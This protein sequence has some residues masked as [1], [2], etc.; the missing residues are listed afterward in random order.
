VRAN[1]LLTLDTS[2]LTEVT[3]GDGEASIEQGVDSL[4]A[5]NEAVSTDVDHNYRVVSVNQSEAEVADRYI[6]NST[7]VYLDNH[8]LIAD[9]QHQSGNHVVEEVYWLRKIG[10]TWK[11]TNGATVS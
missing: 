5:N 6:D 9:Q 4:R 1:A 2:H 7:F 10:S 3:D 11:V 8:Q